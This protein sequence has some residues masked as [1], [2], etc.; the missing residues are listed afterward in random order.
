[1]RTAVVF[2]AA[3]ALV[4]CCACAAK[5]PQ[6]K[7][8][9][10]KKAM[11]EVK[12]AGAEQY[13]PEA[14]KALADKNAAMEAALN[15]KKYEEVAKLADEIKA[16]SANVV[17]EAAK[18]K[19]KVKAD[20]QAAIDAANTSITTAEEAL[21]KAPTGKGSA[22]DL[23]AMKGD[24]EAAKADVP[25]AKAA[26]DAGNYAEATT[27]ANAVKAKADKVSADVQAAIELKAGA[28]K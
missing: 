1:M 4:L 25:K 7:I 2:L 28:K 24:V 19:D 18:G 9:A 8:D 14:Y 21:A 27:L 10:A 11:D 5:P 12:N 16:G 3:V 22:A 17:T 13:A 15:E 6:E 26:W 23:E 20:A